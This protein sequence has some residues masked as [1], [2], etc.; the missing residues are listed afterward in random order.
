MF[1]GNYCRSGRWLLP[2]ESR[3][4]DA[5]LEGQDEGVEEV[6]AL[7]VEGREVGADSAEGGGAFGGAKAAGDF[8]LHL[9][10]ANGLLGEVVAERHARVAGESQHLGC[11][12]AQPA[13][14]IDRETLASPSALAAGWRRGIGCF[15]L[16]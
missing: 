5:T 8:L 9:E 4:R 16:A 2:G 3:L 10:H 15:A 6:E 12:I 1:I 7:L 14:Q 11:L 13:Q